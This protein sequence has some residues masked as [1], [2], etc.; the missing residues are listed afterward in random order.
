MRLTTRL[1]IVMFLSVVVPM[2]GL[3][4]FLKQEIT[5]N[6]LIEKRDKL[7]GLARQLDAALEGNFDDILAEEGVSG[8]DRETKIAVLNSRLRAVTDFV[9][10]GNAGVGV[11]Y[12]G[13]E[14]DAVLTYGPSEQFQYT[15][16][17]S[18]FEGHR[19]YEVMATGKPIVQTGTLVRG[20]ILNCMWPVIRDGE[21]IGYIWSNE[22]LDK[23]GEQLEPIIRRVFMIQA[24]I[25]SL[26][27]VS[28]TMT[29]K[30]LL[31][32]ILAIKRGIEVLFHMPSYHIPQVQGELSIIVT[33]IND[34][35]DTTNL[36]KCYNK[37]ILEGVMNGVLA[38]SCSGVITRANKAF[39]EIFPEFGEGFID[40]S[41][42]DVL[43]P[44][45]GAIVEKGLEGNGGAPGAELEYEGKIIE[46][47]GNAMFDETGSRLGAVFVF[48]DITT[49]R[50][51][52]REIQEKDRA[53][54]L[55]EMALAVVHEVKNP[56][57]SVKGFAQLLGRP[58]VD[59]E[60][61]RK[62]LG[63]IDEDLNR[64]NRLLN[65]M[66]LYG[67]KSRLELRRADLRALV[68]EAVERNDWTPYGARPAVFA[69]R[70][71]DYRAMVDA[72]KVG[73]VLDNVLKNACEAVASKGSGRVVALVKDRG[74]AVEIRVVDSGVGI[75]ADALQRVGNPMF[76]TK[77]TG[78]GFGLAI[79]RKI[80]ESHGGGLF[81][82]SAEGV[83]TA[84][85]LSFP[86]ERAREG[87]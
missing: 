53:A 80:V 81:I 67:G 32:K 66:L 49:M 43:G 15:V 74:E 65:E 76:S 60:K 23:I 73:Q 39:F 24:L 31:D 10:S 50:R 71:G 38:I 22:T 48:R 75:P 5:E 25:I 1:L 78:N 19:G 13:R 7:F 37:S 26:I 52:E 35:V 29:M 36:V 40:S 34:L 85:S 54:V 83:Y 6:I 3:S 4:W 62:Y 57:T 2:L 46:V 27:Y 61:R 44:R 84:V 17:Q 12:Y 70:S 77:K 41:Y 68:A 58:G 14:L 59:E 69:E 8:A 21:T 86:R 55:G 87:D 82:D 63:L 33:T 16:G 72:F 42:R 47:Y 9:A 18:I 45:I 79:S 64:V 51:Y 11:G 28:L 30:G 20:D 56:M